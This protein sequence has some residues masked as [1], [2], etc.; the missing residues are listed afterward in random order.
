MILYLLHLLLPVISAYQYS[1]EWERLNHSIHQQFAILESQAWNR[2]WERIQPG[3]FMYLP[4]PLPSMGEVVSA[5]DNSVIVDSRTH[6]YTGMIGRSCD[7]CGGLRFRD[8]TTVDTCV[9]LRCQVDIQ[10]LSSISYNTLSFNRSM[11]LQDIARQVKEANDD[12][13]PAVGF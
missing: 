6:R 10:L 3:A 4:Y 2:R 11:V 12:I 9:L 8:G 13:A 7:T 5:G 1:E